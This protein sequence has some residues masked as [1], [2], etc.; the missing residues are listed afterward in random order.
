MDLTS[1]TPPPCKQSP[2]P[3]GT[4]AGRTPAEPTLVF[5]RETSPPKR[6]LKWGFGAVVSLRV[7]KGQRPCRAAPLAASLT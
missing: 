5:Q 7:S 2:P 3:A 6:Y 4:T 1:D